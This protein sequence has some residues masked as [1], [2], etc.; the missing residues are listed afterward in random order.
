[1]RGTPRRLRGRTADLA[2]QGI[3]GLLTVYNA[4]ITLA[5]TTAADLGIDPDQISFTVVLRATRDLKLREVGA[6]PGGVGLAGAVDVG[7]F[8][9]SLTTMIP[10]PLREWPP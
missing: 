8:L 5:V 4:L 9:R 7:T 3:W 1:L 6:G 2:E 10:T